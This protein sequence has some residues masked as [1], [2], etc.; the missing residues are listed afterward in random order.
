M[1]HP[2]YKN[3]NWELTLKTNKF[4]YWERKTEDGSQTFYDR[5]TRRWYVP[6]YILGGMLEFAFWPDNYTN[7][8]RYWFV[9]F[10][11]KHITLT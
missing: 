1:T 7:R 11:R 3:Q 6:I 5:T 10:L 9:N 8:F 2:A 4:F